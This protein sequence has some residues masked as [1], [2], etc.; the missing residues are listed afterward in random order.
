MLTERQI[1]DI[2]GL[3]VGLIGFG[4]VVASVGWLAALGL[5]LA[6]TGNNFQHSGRR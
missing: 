6:L 3:V 5:F 2:I 4:C 1:D